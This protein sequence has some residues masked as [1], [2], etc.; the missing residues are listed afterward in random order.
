ME[1]TNIQPTIP[2]VS[3]APMPE[4][5]R[6]TPPPQR[7]ASTSRRRSPVAIIIVVALIVVALLV[8]IAFLAKE[9]APG[10]PLYTAKINLYERAVA[11]TK[12][13]GAAKIA[14][15]ENRIRSRFT[16]LSALTIESGTTDPEIVA[17]VGALIEQH[18]S[19]AVSALNA[20]SLSA[21]DRITALAD[22]S[23]ILRATALLI[24]STE[25]LAPADDSVDTARDVLRDTL[26]QNVT[27]FTT[28]GATSTI[29]TY[30]SARISVLADDIQKIAQGS[31]AQRIAITR[32]TD[33]SEAI[34][35]G[36]LE[37]A[38]SAI[39]RAEEA[40]A[41]DSYLYASERGE[42]PL[43][44]GLAATTTEGQ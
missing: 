10:D 1:P 35:E 21:E 14:Y 38:L 32:I 16:E 6:Q 27:A 20:S 9:T 15:E 44:E 33:A 28:S 2:P 41:V 18:T 24:D 30:L 34:E 7:A 13:T 29:E 23:T 8:A 42:A 40:V 5:P 43:P 4:R 37:F 26:S 31:D 25:E 3:T 36:D 19:A 17:K 22:I 11:T 12:F 39:L